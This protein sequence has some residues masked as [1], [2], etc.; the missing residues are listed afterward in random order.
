M[1]DSGSSLAAALATVADG[2]PDRLRGEDYE[3][4]RVITAAARERL[5]LSR[6]PCVICGG[7]GQD[8]SLVAAITP[9]GKPCPSCGGSG[10]VWPDELVKVVVLAKRALIQQRGQWAPPVSAS[11]HPI[12]AQEARA[13]LDALDLYAKEATK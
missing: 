13:V 4:L 3:A 1:A 2:P 8:N 5:R 9:G 7:T 12:E 6:I 10:E 11:I